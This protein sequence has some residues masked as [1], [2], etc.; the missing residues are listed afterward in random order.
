[1]GRVYRLDGH[2]GFSRTVQTHKINMGINF[3]VDKQTGRVTVLEEA[4]KA[5][6]EEPGVVPKP[7]EPSVVEIDV[8]C[9]NV[10]GAGSQAPEP[11]SS[12]PNA[13]EVD[14]RIVDEGQA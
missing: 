1:M 13:T 2:T 7:K 12:A 11:V 3:V 14:Q 10:S 4:D 8:H 6:K 9:A 5:P